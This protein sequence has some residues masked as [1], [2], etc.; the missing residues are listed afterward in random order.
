MPLIIVVDI[1]LP[2]KHSLHLVYLSEDLADAVLVPPHLPTR[3]CND[4]TSPLQYDTCLC[5]LIIHA[6]A[7]L[8]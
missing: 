5:D 1:C 6:I 7:V 3:L 8:L 4:I 2:M